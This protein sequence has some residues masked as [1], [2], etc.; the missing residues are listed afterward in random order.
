MEHL[1][2]Q[3]EHITKRSQRLPVLNGSLKDVIE[4]K[5]SLEV[6]NFLSNV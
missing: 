2:V 1:M 4:R 3:V 5:N 6:L